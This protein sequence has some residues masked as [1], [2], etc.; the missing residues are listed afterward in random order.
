MLYAK[1]QQ[2]RFQTNQSVLFETRQFHSFICMKKLRPFVE[3]ELENLGSFSL[4]IR[5]YCEFLKP[6][7]SCGD[8]EESLKINQT[9][10]CLNR[11]GDCDEL[12][13]YLASKHR[14]ALPI[15]FYH[16]LKIAPKKQLT[17]LRSHWMKRRSW[18]MENSIL[19]PARK[20]SKKCQIEGCLEITVGSRTAL[21]R[22]HR[23]NK[24]KQ[25]YNKKKKRKAHSPDVSIYIFKWIIRYK[26]F[27][28]I[29]GDVYFH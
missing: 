1:N 29:S 14:K 5:L 21:C 15:H 18:S 11:T 28:F 25:N 3:G 26:L 13:M 23:N 22:K 27:Y 20:A 17:D 24:Y 12:R 4:Q 16:V 7:I 8:L 6:A 2:K 9:W 10:A 19:D